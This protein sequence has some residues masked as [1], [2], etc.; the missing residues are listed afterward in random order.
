MAGIWPAQYQTS[1]AT[2]TDRAGQRE[3]RTIFQ[4]PQAVFKALL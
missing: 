2:G 4:A 3:K 1:K